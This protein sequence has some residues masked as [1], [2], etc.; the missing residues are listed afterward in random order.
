MD[1]CNQESSFESRDHDHINIFFPFVFK[2]VYS[3]IEG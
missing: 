2:F 1:M 3:L